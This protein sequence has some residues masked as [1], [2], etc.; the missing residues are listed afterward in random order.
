[1]SER[2]PLF[3]IYGSYNWRPDAAQSWPVNVLHLDADFNYALIGYKNP[4]VQVSNLNDYIAEPRLWLGRDFTPFDFTRLTPYVGLGYRFLFDHLGQ[5][6]DIGGYDRTSEYLYIPLGFEISNQSIAGWQFG[7]NTEFDILLQG[8]QESYLSNIN[9]SYPNLNN[10]QNSG[11]GIRGS[12]D[13]IKKMEHMNILFSPYVH[14]WNI[15]RSKFT[16]AVDTSSQIGFSGYEPGN[17]STEIG[18][19]IGVQF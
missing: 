9:S 19:K 10:K 14:Y 6:S 11:Y 18:A 2:G 17:N 16:T 7:L 1:M 15:R 5:V 13:I 3:G 12:L 4:D 8:W